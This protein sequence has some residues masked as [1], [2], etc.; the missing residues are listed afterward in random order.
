[1]LVFKDDLNRV[2]TGNLNKV[3]IYT[4]SEWSEL[5]SMKL[6]KFGFKV[7]PAFSGSKNFFY[8]ISTKF[9]IGVNY[10]SIKRRKI[11][12]HLMWNILSNVSE[13]F[14][15]TDLLNY[16]VSYKFTRFEQFW[17]REWK[18]FQK[19]W[20]LKI[21]E[22]KLLRIKNFKIIFRGLLMKWG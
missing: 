17:F 10:F 4:E 13:L 15:V 8:T 12:A 22:W 3:F 21:I 19:F 14:S 9:L 5:P 16:A 2:I 18:V 1:M 7:I 11:F 6:S 20:L